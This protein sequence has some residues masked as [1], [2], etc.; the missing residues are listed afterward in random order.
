MSFVARVDGK[1]VGTVLGGHD[2]R[3]GMLWHLAVVPRLRRSG[4]GS[5]LVKRALDAQW[6]RG[7]PKINIM[8][9]KSNRKGL[10]FWRRAHWEESP[11]LVLSK[12]NPRRAK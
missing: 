6:A 4:I 7:I 11:V 5:E 8:V 1:L 12:R 10:R 3:R 2:A 9:L